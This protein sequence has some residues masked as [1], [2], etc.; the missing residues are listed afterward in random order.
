MRGILQYVRD[1]SGAGAA[2]FALVLIPF[3]AMVFGIIGLSLMFYSNQLLHYAVEDA[4]RCASV[5]TTICTNA[6]TT[7]AYALSHFGAPGLSPTFVA[8]KPACGNKV[9][10]TATY[11][12]NAG[13]VNISVPLSATACYPG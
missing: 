6:T 13:L 7:Q 10:G 1:Q 12:L 9:V 5:K 11:P 4:A 2:E 8:S 3:V